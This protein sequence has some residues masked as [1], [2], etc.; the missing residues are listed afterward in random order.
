MGALNQ[1]GGNI[2]ELIDAGAE[3]NDVVIESISGGGGR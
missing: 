1:P 2:G 3:V